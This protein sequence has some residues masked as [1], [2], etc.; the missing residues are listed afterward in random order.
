[1]CG[2]S[3]IITANGA[4]V[5]REV[6]T[7]MNRAMT[8]RGPDG[9]GYFV[10][11]HVGLGHRRLSIIDLGGGAQP[12]YNE[13]RSVVVVFNG[14]IYNF[15]ELTRDLEARGHQFATRS[16]TEV[17]VHLYE[18][19][20]EAM[21]GKLR[22]MFAFA[23]YDLRNDVLLLARDRFGIKPLYYH[24]RNGTLYFA[25][26]IKPLIAAG[27]VPE[28][29]R[30][31][32]HL[33]LQSRF[34]H[35]DETLFSKVYRLAEGAL[36]RWQGGQWAVRS[37]YPNPAV[38]G[39]D[40]ERDYQALFESALSDAVDSH[41]VAD[42]PVGAYLSGGID[43]AAVVAE[44]ATRTSHPVRTF[45]VDFEGSGSEASA[46]EST[47]KL[48]GCEHQSV[49]C[50][51]D[52][53]LELPAVI[54][55]LEEPVGDPVVV[56]QYMLSRATR[57][58]GIKVVMT[59]DG[60][61]EILGGYQYL[62]AII[63]AMHWQPFI[64]A[65]LAAAL[66]RFAMFVPLGIVDK[67]TN[68]PLNLAQEARTRLAYLLARLPNGTEQEFYDLLLA[69]HRPDELKQVYSPAFFAESQSFAIDSF[70]GKS[71][72]QSLEDRV[73]S[74]Q[75]R[76]WLPANI[77]MKQDKLAMAHSVETRVP[78]LD[79]PL[80]EML[81]GMPARVKL[82]GKRNKILLRNAAHRWKLPQSVSRGKKVPFHLPLNR[83]I[84][85]RRLWQ[86]VEDN[87][88]PERINKRGFVSQEYVTFLMERARGGDYLLIKKLFAL[89]ILEIWFR[90][91]IDAEAI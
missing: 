26:E 89:V 28:V 43:S 88:T 86:M 63:R 29:N 69:L 45:C 20:G 60:A 15:R 6:L 84:Q 91:F 80:V 81:A 67:F 24:V 71:V 68:I 9:E 19:Y 52:Q 57:D 49:F 21:L 3:G 39:V 13:D 82:Q 40:D 32:V 61:D 51:V 46:A 42:V 1:M 64:P 50:G 11:G 7:I 34:A 47:A 8:H 77:N 35:G 70:A 31:G 5:E 54:R 78:F 62:S 83:Q 38:K 59:G 22:G 74:I 53:L 90:V 41:M 25:S 75:Y 18:E 2:I 66:S 44:M 55:A 10:H 72:G 4:A 12:I 65:P 37:Y 85:D 23:I 58:A 30:A 48:L 87:L 73:L 36:L 76:K 79:H 17:L 27:Y 33:Y 14:E 16:D 56:A